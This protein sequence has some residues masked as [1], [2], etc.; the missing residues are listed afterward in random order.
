MLNNYQLNCNTYMY[1]TLYVYLKHNLA[2]LL[3]FV[4]LETGW[5]HGEKT[6]DSPVQHFLLK[7]CQINKVLLSNI[8]TQCLF[9]LSSV[10]LLST[11]I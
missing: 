8:A 11:S 6:T 4:G 9:L 10:R 1:I 3:T 7:L 5:T 2:D